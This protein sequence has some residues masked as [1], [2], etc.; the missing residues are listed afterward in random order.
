MMTL[1]ASVASDGRNSHGKTPPSWDSWHAREAL[2]TEVPDDIDAMEAPAEATGDG[3]ETA[4]VVPPP[5]VDEVRKRL[6]NYPTPSSS[7]IIIHHA[8]FIIHHHPG[9]HCTHPLRTSHPLF[10]VSACLFKE[11]EL[12][13]QSLVAIML[14]ATPKIKPK[15][16][17][18]V[19]P[20]H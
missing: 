9:L 14:S 19:P 7:F 17:K 11:A 15:P 8:S 1:M 3:D 5:E 10:S 18:R 12:R 6:R 4:L 20:M 13:Q 2:P 16:K